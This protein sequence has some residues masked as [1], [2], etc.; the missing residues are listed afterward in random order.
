[1]RQ[2]I[3]IRPEPARFRTKNVGHERCPVEEHVGGGKV[4]APANGRESAA[5][6]QLDIDHQRTIQAD[7]DRQLDEHQPA[8]AQRIVVVLADTTPAWPWRGFSRSFLYFSGDASHFRLQLLHLR[9]VLRLLAAQREHA[10]ADQNRQH[11][12][13]DAV[14]AHERVKGV[15]NPEHRLRDPA[16]PAVIEQV[17]E[18]VSFQDIG[19]LLDRGKHGTTACGWPLPQAQSAPVQRVRYVCRAA[20]TFRP[21]R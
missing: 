6:S 21:A 10:A 5:L 4:R 15:Q 16:E 14:I 17:A 20:I 9:R 11:D 13:R 19:D 2:H 7:E 18:M 3:E 1:M 8:A 12:D